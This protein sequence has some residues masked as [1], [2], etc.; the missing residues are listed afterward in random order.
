MLTRV[1]LEKL[2]WVRDLGQGTSANLLVLHR[3]L[4]FDL[5]DWL[6]FVVLWHQVLRVTLR[7]SI[8]QT[9][10]RPH[11]FIITVVIVP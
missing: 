11:R 1:S 4:N 9:H 5:V 10:R 7:L 6:V 3:V 2:L 8:S